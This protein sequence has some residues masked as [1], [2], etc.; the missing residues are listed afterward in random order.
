MK[1]QEDKIL[2]R[3][4]DELK[5]PVKNSYQLYNDFVLLYSSNNREI[6]IK[7]KKLEIQ[8]QN[9]F[10]KYLESDMISIE[11]CSYN[12]SDYAKPHSYIYD[13]EDYRNR[14][15]YKFQMSKTCITKRTIPII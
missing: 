1:L 11:T 13:S 10:S 7:M 8:N 6:R 2:E 3:F 14:E 15:I 9:R 4:I 12:Q 5:K